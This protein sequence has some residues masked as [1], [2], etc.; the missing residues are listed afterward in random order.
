MGNSRSS[1]RPS[2]SDALAFSCQG[3]LAPQRVLRRGC[4][5]GMGRIPMLL[6]ERVLSSDGSATAVRGRQK[7]RQEV[8]DRLGYA[9]PEDVF[10]DHYVRMV[11]ALTIVAGNREVAADAVQEAFARLVRGWDHL[12]RYQDPAGWVRRVA[13]NQIHDDRRSTFRQAKY[14][15]RFEQ[16][17]PLVENPDAESPALW[18]RV[19]A[20]PLKQ[21]TAVALYFVGDFT[22]REVARTMRVSEGTVDQHLHR[23]LETLRGTLEGQW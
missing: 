13:L 16:E 6:D 20:L 19:K 22:A 17:E 7:K 14:L 8:Q 3:F 18:A 4:T 21:R 5:M 2:G 15:A 23:A 9:C 10:R 1:Y 11:Q 12:A